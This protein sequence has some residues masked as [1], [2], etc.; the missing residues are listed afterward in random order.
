MIARVVVERRTGASAL[1]A[2]ASVQEKA[3]GIS[4]T[5]Y[6]LGNRNPA[7]PVDTGGT[8]TIAQ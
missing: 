6:Q 8:R 7:V 1:G 3:L 2:G 5:I 4:R